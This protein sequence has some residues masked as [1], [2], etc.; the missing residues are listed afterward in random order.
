M[1]KAVSSAW[2]EYLPFS[3]KALVTVVPF[4]TVFHTLTPD[5]PGQGLGLQSSP[6]EG[7]APT[8]LLSARRM[9]RERACCVLP[10]LVGPA[11]RLSRRVAAWGTYMCASL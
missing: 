6:F 11:G 1:T 3:P 2:E 4:I 10:W 7:P 9:L 8:T 5:P